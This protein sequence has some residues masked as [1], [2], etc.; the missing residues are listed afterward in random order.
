MFSNTKCLKLVEKLKFVFYDIVSFPYGIFT[1]NYPEMIVFPLAK[2]NIGLRIVEKRPDG[3]H[4]LQTIFYPVR[5][6]DA[7]EYIV[8]EGELSQDHLTETGLATGCPPSENIIIKALKKIR[9]QF[10]IPNLKLH[11]HKAIPTGAGL[12]GGSSDAACFIKSL[13][14]Y[15][16]LG[17]SNDELKEI[18]ADLGSDCPF[19]ID[20]V[21]SYGEG[22]GEI[23]TPVRRLPEDLYLII[24]KPD[25]EVNTGLAYKNCIPHGSETDLIGL[26]NGNMEEWK[27]RMAN[28]FERSV[29]QAHPEIAEAKEELYRMGAL[30]SSMSGSGSAVFGIFRDETR[31]PDPVRNMVVYCGKL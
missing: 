6:T 22:R 1:S 9:K 5:L 8:P 27:D 19:F 4:N 29:F 13:N 17:L 24:L 12:G 25:C 28:D 31:V 2:I 14:R 26:Y 30:Y 23:L 11:L 15:F 21:P 7:L 3:F 16:N 10:Y 20:G 18:A